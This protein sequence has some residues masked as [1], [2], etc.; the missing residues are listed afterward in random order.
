MIKRIWFFCHSNSVFESCQANGAA[1]SGETFPG[2]RNT[3]LQLPLVTRFL[4]P[5]P[6]PLP[7]HSTLDTAHRHKA[8]V[9][10]PAQHQK[11]DITLLIVDRI[12][13]DS[14]ISFPISRVKRRYLFSFYGTWCNCMIRIWLILMFCWNMLYHETWKLI[15]LVQIYNA[16]TIYNYTILRLIW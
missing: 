5:K 12:P 14:R 8:S 1:W 15:S 3:E 2:C 7:C 10:T 4:T 6:H 9:L 13:K 11:W 16:R